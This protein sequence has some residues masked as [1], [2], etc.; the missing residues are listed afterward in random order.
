MFELE[1]KES[2]KL[3]NCQ[4]ITRVEKRKYNQKAEPEQ[5]K[6]EVREVLLPKPGNTDAM[7]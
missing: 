3:R 2:K 5:C 4:G 7:H 6:S 1:K